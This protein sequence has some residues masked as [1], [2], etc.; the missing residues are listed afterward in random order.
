[1]TYAEQTITDADT[2]RFW[3]HVEQRDADAC[4]LYLG[5]LTDGYGRYWWAGQTGAA[6]R[7][8]W[9]ITHGTIPDGQHID[10]L[11]RNRACVNPAHLEPVT[12]AE[13]VLRGMG[14]S[15]ANS[16]KTECHRGH[17][18]TDDNTYTSP[19]GARNCKQCRRDAVR[20]WRARNGEAAA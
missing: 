8:A 10:H 13:N 1:M 14:I 5:A 19:A 9:V 4:W 18:F 12:L 6:H 17:P 15:A 3:R 2:Q 11:C 20:A 7:F 16:R